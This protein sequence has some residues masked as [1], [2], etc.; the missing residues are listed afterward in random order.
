MAEP[1][2]AIRRRTGDGSFAGEY[3]RRAARLS[4]GVVLLST[5]APIVYVPIHGNYEGS[6][7]RCL[8][9]ARGHSDMP[10]ESIVL[11][12]HGAPSPWRGRCQTAFV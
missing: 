7:N 3:G 8:A 12:D 9:I 6:S 1:T 10:I 5:L 4:G 2:D 11:I